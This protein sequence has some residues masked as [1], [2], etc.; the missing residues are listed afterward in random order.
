MVYIVIISFLI[1]ISLG[2][3]VFKIESLSY[4]KQNLDFYLLQ[5]LITKQQ[6]IWI[7]ES[8]NSIIKDVALYAEDIVTGFNIPKSCLSAP[9]YTGYQKYY[10]VDQTNGELYDK[11]RP[12][13]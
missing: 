13:F 1:I 11:P 7:N 2:K 5:G 3:N 9:I 6:A 10:S 4:L 8:L 12:K